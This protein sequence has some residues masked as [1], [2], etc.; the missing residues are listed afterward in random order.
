MIELESK[1]LKLLDLI[2]SLGEYLNNDDG[3][4]RGKSM[5]MSHAFVILRGADNGLAMSY[6]ADVLQNVPQKVLSVQQSQLFQYLFSTDI[7]T[8]AISESC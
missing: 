6:L 1:E 2:Q 4:I 8:H 3:P 5:A 7:S